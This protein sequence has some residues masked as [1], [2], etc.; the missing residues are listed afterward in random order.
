M[1]NLTLYHNNVLIGSEISASEMEDLSSPYF[2]ADD[3]LSF[4]M[5]ATGIHTTIQI[6]Q[7]GSAIDPFQY[8]VL[9][10]HTMTGGEVV[11]RTFPTDARATE[12]VLFSGTLTSA[13]PNV[14]DLTLQTGKQYIDVELTAS[15]IN[16]AS[17]GELMLASLFESPQRP[18]EGINTQYLPRRTFIALENGEVV[19]IKHAETVRQKEYVIPGLS[20]DDAGLWI[21]LFKDNEGAELVV[22]NDDE[23]DTYPAYMNQNLGM[24]T[25]AR[26][27][28]IGLTFVEV[29]L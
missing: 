13:D 15:G 22:L 12:T 1:A 19:S 29:K 5:T 27:V 17:A 3:R 2:L 24:N 25:T 20:L 21:E 14:I 26:R 28:S 18:Q 8:L 4:K 11:V 16:K 7:P 23:G 10:D 9:V 6:D